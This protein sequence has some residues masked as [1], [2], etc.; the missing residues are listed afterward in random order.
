MYV[1]FS[2]FRSYIVTHSYV[3]K[4]HPQVTWDSRVCPVQNLH[5]MEAT[6]ALDMV[7]ASLAEKTKGLFANARK[8]ILDLHV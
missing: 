8:D 1:K 3:K 5:V 2:W 7:D 4:K 6:I